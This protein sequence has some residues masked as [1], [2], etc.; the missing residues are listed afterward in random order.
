MDNKNKAVTF[1]EMIVRGQIDE[2][3]DEFVNLEGKHHNIYFEA[4]FDALKKAMKDNHSQFPD[5][6]LDVIL[7]VSENELVAVYTKVKIE[8]KN[9]CITH[10]FKFDAGKIVEMWDTAQEVPPTIINKDGAF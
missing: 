6:E 4:G 10:F 2:A 5:K 7:T 9:Y 1:L 3:Y 8:N